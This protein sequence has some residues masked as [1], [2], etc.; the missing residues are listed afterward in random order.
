M[1][2]PY[3]SIVAISAVVQSPAFSVEKQ[4]ML[5]AM[6]SPLIPT[7]T[8]GLEFLNATAFSKYF[9]TD[10]AEYP[11]VVKYFSRLSKTG[12]APEKLIVARWYK[13]AAAPFIKGTSDI[14][15]LADLKAVE[16]GSFTITFGSNTL[17]V[18]LNLT[19]ANAYS[20]IAA[21]IQTALRA[22]S[23]GG[24]AFTS[25]NVEYNTVTDGFIITGGETGNAA[26]VSAVTA[27]ETGTDVS[28]ML[29]L[30]N[31]ELSQGANAET[32]A[33]FCDRIYNANTAGFS[34]TTLETLEQ[35]EI[36]A[37]AEWLQTVTNGQTYNTAVRLVFNITELNTA[38]TVASSLNEKNYTGFV[39]CYDPK[40]E[41]VN[42]LDC[43]ICAA[44]DYEAVDGTINFNFQPADGY[45][46]IT[47]LGTVTDYQSGQTNLNLVEELDALKISYVY[48]V[49]FGSQEVVYYGKGLMAGSFGNEAEQANEAW[50]EKQIQTSI[51][52]GLD[53]VNKL[54]LQGER[55][56]RA[57]SAWLNPPFEQS[58]TNG[59]T[60]RGGTLTDTDKV[61]IIQA[62]GNSAAVDAVEA[63][64]YYF[65]ILP[66]N[67]DDRTN[68]RRRVVTCRLTSGVVN[69]VRITNN[70][71]GV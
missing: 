38:K 12:L 50:L 65:Q 20:D 61:S 24:A 57:L 49:G 36:E 19:T 44:V 68:T 62:T 70:I 64:G 52:N 63:N 2:L 37:A 56:D 33:E 11:Q 35:A 67:Q 45:T 1:S 71:Y 46:P 58:I 22:N 47:T 53:A 21:L 39:L 28:E 5:L 14:S 69:Q 41:F 42:V 54:P 43:A 55:A 25:A 59:M 15:S 27:G 16:N 3:S 7:S 48:S 17:D 32:F 31:A 51:I 4:H 66:V 13:T 6:T 8:M 29:G 9:G 26:T 23:D 60:A 30:A 18:V 10:L 34:F 40:N